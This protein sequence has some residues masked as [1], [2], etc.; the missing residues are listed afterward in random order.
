[1]G[2]EFADFSEERKHLCSPCFVSFY[3]SM[4]ILPVHVECNAYVCIH[5][6]KP[7]DNTRCQLPVQFTFSSDISLGPNVQLKPKLTGQA[8]Q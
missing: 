1:M 3:R 8:D 7:E 5:M 4:C 6:W 2:E